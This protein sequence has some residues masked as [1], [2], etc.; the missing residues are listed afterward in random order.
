MPKP[1]TTATE[2]LRDYYLEVCTNN[3]EVSRGTGITPEQLSRFANGHR[4]LSLDNGIVLMRYLGW[5]ITPPSRKR[6]KATT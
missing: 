5:T 6:R 2:Q 4:G 3:S 1:D